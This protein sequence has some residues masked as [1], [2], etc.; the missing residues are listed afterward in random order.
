MGAKARLERDLIAAQQ[1]RD[2]ALARAEQ[3]EAERNAARAEL[4][5][6][7]AK[8]TLAG[9]VRNWLDELAQALGLSL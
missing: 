9:R 5:R 1:Q 6:I 4:R 3:A 7:Q 8:P 2:R